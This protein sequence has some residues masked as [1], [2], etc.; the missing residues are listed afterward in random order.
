MILSLMNYLDWIIL[1]VLSA[2]FV[3]GFIKGIIK[4]AFSLGGL[5]LGIVFGTLLY[6]PFAGLLHNLLNI[7][8][9]PA[10][11]TAFIIILLVI[12][13]VCGIVG[14]ILSKMVHA[15]N[16]GFIDR[17]TGALFGLFKSLLMMGLVILLMDMIG[18]S[19]RIIRKEEKKQSHLYVPVRNISSF[20][21]RWTWNKVQSVAWDMVPEYKEQDTTEQKIV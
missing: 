14:K 6:R 16:L 19:D 7:S 4:Q 20:C 10:R 12:P 9:K 1:A 11:I 15:A 2:G 17:I 21:L 5:V 13:M 18:V 8:D 3:V